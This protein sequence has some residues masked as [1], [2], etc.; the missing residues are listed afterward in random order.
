MNN[1]KQVCLRSYIFSG[2]QQ[3]FQLDPFSFKNSTLTSL[4]ERFDP[5]LGDLSIL[6]LM[7][8]SSYKVNSMTLDPIKALIISSAG[9]ESID[10]KNTTDVVLMSPVWSPGNFEQIIGRAQRYR[11]C[12]NKTI[13]CTILVLENSVDEIVLKRMTKK[14][15]NLQDILDY[16]SKKF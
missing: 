9:A 13:E 4:V 1:T 7:K 10:L 16:L 12:E 6:K 15:Q 5:E 11:C 3:L 14:K 8:L 2:L